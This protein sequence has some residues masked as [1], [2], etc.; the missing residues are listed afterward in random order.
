[1]YKRKLF[2][3]VLSSILSFNV[4][5]FSE[6]SEKELDFMTSI[7]SG[8]NVSKEKAAAVVSI[9]TKEDINKIG[10]LSIEEALETVPGLYVI[11]NDYFRSNKYVFRGMGTKFNTEALFMINGTPIKSVSSGNR[12]QAGFAGMP[13]DNVEKI[14]IIRGPGSALYGADAYSGIINI[15]MKK[16]TIANK[17]IVSTRVGDLESKAISF[18]SSESYEM[19]DLYFSLNYEKTNENE[20]VVNYDSQS[21]YDEIFNTEASLA[22]VSPNFQKEI[23]DSYLNLRYGNFEFTNLFQYRKDLGT[24]YGANDSIDLDG[25]F[26]NKRNLAKL[27]YRNNFS[28]FEVDANASYFIMKEYVDGY[29]KFFPDG[30]FGGAFPNGV[31]ATPERTDD[32]LSFNVKSLYTG[33]EDN[34]FQFGVGYTI[35]RVYDIKDFRNYNI[36]NSNMIVPKPEGIVDVSNDQSEVFLSSEER[37]NTYMFL[38][39][40]FYFKK[41]WALTLGIRYD[42]YNDFGSTINPRAA[43]VWN[44]N[45]K[46]TTKLLYGRAFRAPSFGELY[47]RSN[48][49]AFANEDLSAATIDTYEFSFNYDLSL[50]SELNWNIFYYETKD[51]IEPSLKD[52]GPVFENIGETRGYGGE[53]ELSHS[54]NDAVSLNS[55]YSYQQSYN[56]RTGEETVIYPAHMFYTRLNFEF[57]SWNAHLQGNLIS[58]R[59]RA[60]NDVRDDLDAYYRIDFNATRKNL[61]DI[62]G[63]NAKLYVKNLTDEEIKNPSV[64][65]GI[66]NDYPMPGR[67]FHVELNYNF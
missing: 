37:V 40:E 62:K 35:N 52:I 67:N 43:L 53:V 33:I 5:P 10:A 60:D 20:E 14:E 22:S 28:D 16:S 9:I 39:N 38:Q 47:S 65:G 11:K 15:V 30:A 36:N 32:T 50:R 58:D 3:L 64:N 12:T 25:N 4:Y 7:A 51:Q 55:N 19:L 34:Y 44:T 49:V 2:L 8:R 42:H 17:N 26:N 46:L 23:I 45:Q 66:K 57:K 6:V 48:P 31:I 27:S 13:L 56:K 29:L 59:K 1:M 54:F 61:L 24:G 21:Y 41:D 18:Q 63:L